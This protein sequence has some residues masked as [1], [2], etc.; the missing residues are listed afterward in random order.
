MSDAPWTK[1]QAE[2]WAKEFC[3]EWPSG[4]VYHWN[5]HVWRAHRRPD[6]SL[7]GTHPRFL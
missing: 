3:K 2:K 6:Q 4:E 5:D 1:E 7:L